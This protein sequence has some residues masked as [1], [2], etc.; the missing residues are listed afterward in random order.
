MTSGAVVRVLAAT[1]HRSPLMTIC[2]PFIVQLPSHNCNPVAAASP[3]ILSP[4]P[5]PRATTVPCW[6]R[7]WT[8]S[9]PIDRVHSGRRARSSPARLGT[10]PAP[11]PGA[12]PGGHHHGARPGAHWAGRGAGRDTDGV[13]MVLAAPLI[14]LRNHS[15]PNCHPC[16]ALHVRLHLLPDAATISRPVMSRFAWR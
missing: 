13:G 6:A 8:G 10:H 9:L 5:T 7:I 14:A 4:C 2:A 11:R 12:H 16:A 3:A 1:T 15:P